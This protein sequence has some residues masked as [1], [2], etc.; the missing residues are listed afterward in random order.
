MELNR[1]NYFDGGQTKRHW[2]WCINVASFA[3]IYEANT[4][5]PSISPA[6]SIKTLM[7]KYTV[8][9]TH[10]EAELPETQYRAVAHVT[11]HLHNEAKVRMLN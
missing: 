4:A 3:L 1:D 2:K 10:C 7:S 11:V 8:I 9:A 5:Q 6:L